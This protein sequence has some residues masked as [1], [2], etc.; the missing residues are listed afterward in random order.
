[1]SAEELQFELE[2]LEKEKFSLQ[3]EQ[4]FI[5]KK[6]YQY[7]GKCTSQEEVLKTVLQKMQSAVKK[8]I[9]RNI[10][11]EDITVLTKLSFNQIAKY[12]VEQAQQNIEKATKQIKD[13]MYK[14]YKN[15]LRTIEI[16]IPQLIEK[17]KQIEEIK[18][19][20]KLGNI[21][22]LPLKRNLSN[23]I[24]LRTMLKEEHSVLINKQCIIDIKE[25]LEFVKY[26]FF[27]E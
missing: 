25:C 17:I 23:M 8:K 9:D 7:I 2:K 22:L 18:V 13:I 6:I 11:Q 24:T 26:M 27:L 20:E 21:A 1:M 4:I 10:T 16:F 19:S 14:E 3:L 15:I 12:N 5:C